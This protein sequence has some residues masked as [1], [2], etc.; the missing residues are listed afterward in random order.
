MALGRLASWLRARSYFRQGAKANRSP[1]PE[2]LQI[3]Y[4]FRKAPPSIAGSTMSS[5]TVVEELSRAAS[6][7]GLSLPGA[8]LRRSSSRFCL[9]VE[10]G[11][12]NGTDLFGVGTD[13]FIWVAYHANASGRMR[14]FSGNFPEDGL[15]DFDLAETPPPRT[16]RRSWAR[17]PWGVAYVLRREGYPVTRGADILVYGNIPG[18]GMSR[19]AS[20][21]LNLIETLFELNGITDVAGLRIVELAQMVENDYI[22]SPCGYLDQIMIYF[23]RA[24]QGTLFSPREQLVKHIPLGPT[25]ID[26]RIVGLD[27]GTDRPGLEKSTYKARRT[28][29]EELVDLTS[30]RFGIRCLADVKVCRALSGNPAGLRSVP[31]G[32]LPPPQVHLRSAKPLCPYVGSLEAG[33]YCDGGE[34]LSR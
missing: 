13:R 29:C 22:G 19:S 26:F 16:E 27:T 11:D 33:R 10:H 34:D 18:G 6:L 7:S 21:T 28:E 17:F 32:S 1:L 2:Q 25:A 24:G 5:T 8:R 9:G 3:R 23:A 12:Y 31:S 15:I 20:L 14:L 4:L 30:E